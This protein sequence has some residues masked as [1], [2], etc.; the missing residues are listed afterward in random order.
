MWENELD[1]YLDLLQKVFLG[2]FYIVGYLVDG[3]LNV[4]WMVLEEFCNFFYIQ[5]DFKIVLFVL[6]YMDYF[7]DLEEV[8]LQVY[9]LICD[10][11]VLK[12]YFEE[13]EYLW[14]NYLLR[15]EIFFLL[16]GD[17][18]MYF[19]GG[20]NFQFVFVVCIFFVI[21]CL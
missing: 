15:C 18:L 9:D 11:D 21:I 14:G 5:V 13:F 2:I 7:F 17:I 8:F 16:Q 3:K 10:S 6:L 4:I 12:W 20:Q 1:I 19:Y